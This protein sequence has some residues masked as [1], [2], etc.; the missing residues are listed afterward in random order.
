MT[1][2]VAD[3]RLQRQV[4]SLKRKVARLEQDKEWAERERASTHR[5]AEEAWEEVRRLHDVCSRHHEDKV[6]AEQ[7]LEAYRRPVGA[8]PS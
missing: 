8:P 1:P 5:W 4:A 3:E 6:R 2:P 7:A